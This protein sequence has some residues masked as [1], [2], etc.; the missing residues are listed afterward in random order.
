MNFWGKIISREKS[1]YFEKLFL[2]KKGFFVK[3]EIRE[4]VY[5]QEIQFWRK[6]GFLVDFKNCFQVKINGDFC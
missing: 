4:K 3:I 6:N 1:G 2:G 5:F